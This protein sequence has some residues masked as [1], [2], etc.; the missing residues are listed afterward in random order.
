M[1]Q[2]LYMLLG[3]IDFLKFSWLLLYLDMPL[4]SAIGIEK[5]LTTATEMTCIQI[6]ITLLLLQY[7]YVHVPD[8]I[9]GHQNFKTREVCR[10]GNETTI[11]YA[12]TC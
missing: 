9:P 3:G 8:T 11:E 2:V 5:S 1:S 6:E 10:S 7:N 4:L 12:R